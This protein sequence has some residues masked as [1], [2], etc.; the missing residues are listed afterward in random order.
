MARPPSRAR[1]LRYSGTVKA[2]RIGLLGVG[3][4]GAAVAKAIATR[5]DVLAR[6][7]RAT[8]VVQRAAVRD[9]AKERGLSLDRVTTDPLEVVRA[10]DVDVVVELL[11]GEEPAFGLMKEA[12][13]RGKPVVTANKRVV[14]WHGPEL[15]DL[16]ARKGVELRYEAAVGG[17][18]PLLAPLAD[19]LAANRLLEL[20]A[21]INGTTNYILT[22]MAGGSSF[23]DALARA[24][25]LGY[26]EADPSDDVDAVDAADKLAILVRIAFG[27]SCTP[28]EIFREG[29]R[30][31]DPIDLAYGREMGYALKLLAIARRGEGGIEA[32]VHPAFLPADHP[33]ARV[34]GARNA[35]HLLGDL[36]GPVMFSGLGAGGDATAS[37][38]LADLTH[39]ARRLALGDPVEPPR[40]GHTGLPV[41]PMD[42]V[43][44]R[45][46]LRLSVDDVPGVFAQITHVLAELGIGL[47]SVIQREPVSGQADVV[48][49]TYAAREAALREAQR[50]LAALPTTRSVRARIRVEESRT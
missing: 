32:R 49:M 48:L 40:P 22:Q 1:G 39:V 26:A 27:V 17:G 5:G 28:K 8:L 20:R 16:A 31:L 19:D 13:E 50:R 38:V 24:Q 43:R 33:L 46:Y 47:A 6:A 23:Q 44:A 30:A 41:L 21:I 45:S 4:V 37:A 29:V 12:I 42:E 15:H 36:C 35:V 34:D 7:S 2:V 11:G 3:T 9:P 18:I 25:K 14:S 10:D